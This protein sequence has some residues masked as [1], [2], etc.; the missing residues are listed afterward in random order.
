[1]NLLNRR[2]LDDVSWHLSLIDEQSLNLCAS[3]EFVTFT[4]IPREWNGVV[5]CLAK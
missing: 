3:L 2:H 4:H 5:D 1:M